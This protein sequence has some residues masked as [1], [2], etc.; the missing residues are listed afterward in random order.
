MSKISFEK[1]LARL[2]KPKIIAHLI[3]SL[4]IRR[5]SKEG[6]AHPESVS[7]KGVHELCNAIV[8][9]NDGNDAKKH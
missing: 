7:P 4:H 3:G 5:L 8:T 1:K 6:I 9:H 2:P